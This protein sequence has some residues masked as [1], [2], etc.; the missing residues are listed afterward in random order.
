MC[1]LAHSLENA[2]IATVVISLI[3][4]HSDIIRPPRAL[5]VPFELGRPLGDPRDTDGQKAVLRA[6]LGLLENPGPGPVFGAFEG[7]DRTTPT[8]VQPLPRADLD[9]QAEISDILSL[10]H[11]AFVSKGRT[12]FG[13]SGLTPKDC[14]AQFTEL[15]RQNGK[16]T[17]RYSGKHLRFLIDDL[18]TIYFEAACY[19]QPPLASASLHNWFWQGTRAGAV[20]TEMRADFLKSDNKSLKLVANFI[21]PGEWV[22]TLNL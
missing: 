10:Y 7:R 17:G 12:T 6:A 19:Q 4:M 20:L 15:A 5:F 21:V 11:R 13:N 3:R 22:D 18:K 16:F 1:T 9:F 8:T 2:G 14:C